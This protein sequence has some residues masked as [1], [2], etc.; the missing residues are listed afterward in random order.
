MLQQHTVK[1]DYD[2]TNSLHVPERSIFSFIKT[3]KAAVEASDL[4]VGDWKTQ[5]Q[6]GLVKTVKILVT[7]V[8]IRLTVLV[9]AHLNDRTHSRFLKL[10]ERS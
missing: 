3:V 2:S 4:T 6:Q 7:D 5:T 10:D 8:I 9:K 1:V